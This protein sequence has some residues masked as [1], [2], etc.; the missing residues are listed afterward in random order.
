MT[1]LVNKYLTAEFP[2]KIDLAASDLQENEFDGYASVF[3]VLN[4]YGFGFDAGA[5]TKTLQENPNPVLL[6]QH[7]TDE[8]IG[9]IVKAEEDKKG[10]KIRGAMVP[11]V[12]KA[13]EARALMMAGAVRGLS[14]GFVPLKDRMDEKKNA[15]FVTEAKLREVSAVTFAADPK[16]SISRVLSDLDLITRQR[17]DLSR[18]EIER[19]IQRLTALRDEI[20]PDSSTLSPSE[21]QASALCA[22]LR[23]L[24]N[25]QR[26]FLP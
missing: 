4:S 16:A 17:D 13:Q 18:D 26:R 19:A 15:W 6:W 3:G 9:V 7:N 21:P 10:L 8:P 2:L 23:T 1:S 14:I 11:E 25:E 24:R 22:L 12:T 20:E 5:F